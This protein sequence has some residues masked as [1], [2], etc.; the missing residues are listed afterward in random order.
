MSHRGDRK[1][2]KRYY[3]GTCFLYGVRGKQGHL[4]P[5]GGDEIQQSK[6]SLNNKSSKL[7]QM[8]CRCPAWQVAMEGQQRGRGMGLVFGGRKEEKKRR[9]DGG[10]E[11]TGRRED[12]GPH[13]GRRQARAGG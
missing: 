9:G 10:P 8:A 4:L 3:S 11:M 6:T 7:N 2:L 5:P 12:S 1:R 13:G